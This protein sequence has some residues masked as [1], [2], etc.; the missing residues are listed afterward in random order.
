MPAV[1]H[2]RGATIPCSSAR[3][4]AAD[5][6]SGRPPGLGL[7]THLPDIITEHHHRV[8]L[9]S[10][11]LILQALSPCALWVILFPGLFL[12]GAVPQDRCTLGTSASATIE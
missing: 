10:P 12:M 11:S 1:P 4:A 3:A 8:A 9:L 2:P 6:D 7:C 5:I